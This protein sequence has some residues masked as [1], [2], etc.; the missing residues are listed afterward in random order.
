NSILGRERVNYRVGGADGNSDSSR[1]FSILR[2]TL[3]TL[4][5]ALSIAITVP[6]TIPQKFATVFGPNNSRSRRIG[7]AAN[8]TPA[9]SAPAIV[10][11]VS[12]CFRI[13]IRRRSR[14]ISFSGILYLAMYQA[15]FSGSFQYPHVHWSRSLNFWPQKAQRRQLGH[16]VLNSTIAHS[17]PG[18]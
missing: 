18:Q 2:K 16:R 1:R 3:R 10:L 14:G 6:I 11:L 12:S 15:A 4:Q 5:W 8:G 13:S 9:K 17:Q 7:P